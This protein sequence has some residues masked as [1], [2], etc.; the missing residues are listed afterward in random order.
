M[1]INL[2]YYEGRSAYLWLVISIIQAKPCKG[3]L[4]IPF[5]SLKSELNTKFWIKKMH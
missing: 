4:H 2:A 1:L 5:E 3:F